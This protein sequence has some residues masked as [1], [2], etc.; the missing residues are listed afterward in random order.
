VAHGTPASISPNDRGPAKSSRPGQT[1]RPGVATTPPFALAAR[2]TRTHD[3]SIILTL[4]RNGKRHCS[5]TSHHA[6]TWTY[7][8]DDNH[9]Q[10]CTTRRHCLQAKLARLS[11][12][13][14]R[15]LGRENLLYVTWPWTLYKGSQGIL[16]SSSLD[17]QSSRSGSSSPSFSFVS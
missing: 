4:G 5:I 12:S 8:H 11:P 15:P 7:D 3:Y 10:T 1:L 17:S 14:S 16:S 9:V 13:G 6:T 2:H